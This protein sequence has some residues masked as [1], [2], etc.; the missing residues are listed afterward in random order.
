MSSTS[1]QFVRV[2]LKILDS[3]IA[4]D[5]R[6]RHVFEDLFKLCDYKT[7]VLD[8]TRQSLSRRLNMPIEE[9]NRAIEKLESPDPN[10]RDQQFDGRR[11]EKLDAHRDWGWKI[12]NWEKYREILKKSSGAE[13]TRNCR[14]ESGD[15]INP[16]LE[17]VIQFC[18]SIGL[19]KL[20]AEGFYWGKESGKE[21]GR[22]M[23]GKYPMKDWK[24]TIR[25]WKSYG[26]MQ[27]QKSEQKQKKVVD[28]AP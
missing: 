14:S 3:S 10:S 7:G 28:F 8:M 13:R 9:I 22:W 23:N 18:E 15:F 21:G 16:T 19:Q 26:Y 27:S 4:E 6:V 2:F 20:D 12:L 1:N 11:I 17:E 5:Y 25:Q 24:A